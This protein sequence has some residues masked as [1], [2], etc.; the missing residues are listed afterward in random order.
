[1]S[2]II[3]N[4]PFRAVF[5]AP[6]YAAEARGAFAR[7]GL[8]LQMINVGNPAEAAQQLIDGTADLAWSGPMRPMQ[9]LSRDPEHPLRCFGAVVMKDPFLLIG[10]GQRPGFRI[11][12][13]AGLRLG[14]TSEVPTPWW[15]LQDDIRRA[16][17]DPAGLDLVLGRTMPE[18]AAALLAGE[19]DVAMLFEP[20]GAALEE[21]GAA[22]WYAAAQR[23]PT[24][25]SAFYATRAR[26]ASRRAE[27]QA[28][29]R[30]MADTQAWITRADPKEIA[31]LVAPH[32]PDTPPAQLHRAL[33][34]YQSLGIWAETP[35]F[36]PAA[37]DR[38]AHAM[39][40]SGVMTRHPG[41]AACVD[42]ELEESA[43]TL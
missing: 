13:L 3:L 38:L 1:L 41:F 14:V 12:D 22:V 19:I 11:A 31:M 7:Q 26:I 25:Y 35:H 8:D 39:I 5:Y 10:R 4:E 27:F 42:A 37:L 43:L 18:N 29:I 40:S 9:N 20:F 33:A 16:G 17:L 30:A 6:F 23:G 32:F 15:C 21:R 24:S 34:R 36:P 28:M 2:P